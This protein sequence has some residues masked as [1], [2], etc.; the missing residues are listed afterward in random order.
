MTVEIALVLLIVVAAVILFVS[1]RLRV[2]V[3]ALLVLGALV[4]TQ[5]ITPTEALSGFSNP[6]VVTVWAVF[7]LSGALARTGVAQVIGR[8]VMRVAGNGEFRLLLM[9]MLTAA[10]LSAFMN[11]VGVAALLL[12]VVMEIARRTGTPPSK[13]L[14]PLAI[15]ALLGGLTTLIGTPPNILASDALDEAGLQPFTLFDFAPV[16]AAILVAGIFFVLLV[17]RRLLPTRN[18]VRET[19]RSESTD[20]GSL[21]ELRDQL[22]IL[23]VPRDSLLAGMTLA[24]SQMGSLLDLHVLAI[25]HDGQTRLSPGADAVLHGG[26]QLIVVGEPGQ[27]SE[28][29]QHRVDTIERLPLTVENIQTAGIEVAELSLARKSPLI[30]KNLA[31]TGF[32]QKYGLNILAVRRG[33]QFIRNNLPS[34]EFKAADTLLIQGRS[35]TIDRLRMDDS[36]DVLETESALIFKLGERLLLVNVP[37][38][39]AL[40]GKSLAESRLG[41]SFGLTV[42][43][44][45]RGSETVALPDPDVKVEINDTL[46]VQSSQENVQALRGLE[47]L[48]IDSSLESLRELEN[49]QI[50]LSEVVLSPRTT[51]A[52]KTLKELNFREKFDL[53]VVAIWRSGE[54]YHDDI[55]DMPLRFG[56]ALL[57]YGH[58]SKMNILGQEPDFIVL[59]EEA[60]EAPRLKKAPIAV[61]IMIAV[62]LVVLLGWL[63]IAIAAVIGGTLMVVTGCLTMEE[64][65]RNIEWPAV[66]LIAAMLPLGI[67]LQTSG[68][69]TYL[70]DSMIGVIGDAGPLIVLVGLFVLTVLASQV[71]PNA[72]VVVLMAPIAI[73]SATDLGV[74]PY[75][76]MMGIAIAAS[77]SF[78]SPISHPANILVMG[79]GG[80]RFSD[81]IKVGLPLT[82]VV[83]VVVLIVLPLVW[84]F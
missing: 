77:A 80:Y 25:V 55:S 32:R 73:G 74:S 42:L 48:E 75:A 9:I 15:G 67:A 65:Y 70:T 35:E 39:S 1:G 8:Q 17:G 54:A 3:V 66:F 56:D 68:A 31:Q 61:G 50:G 47:E 81:Y 63:P 78:M 52:G 57:V 29:R 36:F 83:L 21:Y 27:L 11:N 7:I 40:V 76:F 82:V 43:Q 4:I 72:A 45:V 41:E 58:R 18:M 38:H 33:D 22:L 19:G 44:I 24:D 60:Q 6:A 51:M 79:P 13:L 62:L 26:D 69:A 71:M 49:S 20:L 53:S 46:L 59:T 14:L 64:A 16:G 37:E 23:S 12:P 30:G 84:P 2:D 34:L 5:L 10:I 28:L